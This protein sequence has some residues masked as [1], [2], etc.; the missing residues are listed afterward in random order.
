MTSIHA[1]ITT[2][3]SLM[4]GVIV[5]M[6][7]LAVADL[8]LL[9]RQVNEGAAVAG[10]KDTALE[11]RRF[12]KNLLL[13]GDRETLAEVR[14][15]RDDAAD[16]L[17][18]HRPTLAAVADA[19][20]LARLKADLDDYAT[21]LDSLEA[22][23]GAD[24]V[25]EER[26]RTVGHRITTTA[27]EMAQTERRILAQSVSR[28]RWGLVIALAL[29]V[30]AVAAIGRRFAAAVVRPLRRMEADLAPIAEG[31]LDH[32]EARTDDLE[33]VTFAAAF[34]RMLAELESRRRRLLQSEKLASLGVLVAGVAHELN[35]PL[36]NISSSAQLLIEDLDSADRKLLAQWAGQIESETERARRIV[37]ALLDFG[38]QRDFSL[39]PAAL[40]RLLEKTLILLQ[41]PLR[42]SGAR[43]DL[44]VPGDIVIL[45]DEQRLQQV[46]INLV[47]NAME[48][49]EDRV[50]IRIT[51]SPCGR[52]APTLPD[53]A[54]VIGNPNCGAGG[55]RLHTQIT[56][57]DDGPGIDPDILPR[58]FDPFFTTHEP[59][60]GYGLGLYIVQEIIQE[61]EGCIA[62]ASAPGRGTR[63]LLRLPCAEEND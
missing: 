19:P 26:I 18:L 39:T 13:Y 54:E 25:L 2:A 58:I 6:A 22:G 12:E 45:A 42:K 40:D 50:R 41:G 1:R 44:E 8:A 56:V 49:T 37:S 52:H 43:I 17:A 61:H 34:N 31:R 23:P 4:I 20:T 30:L 53:D 60:R 63:F 7:V 16:K 24:P 5:V 46:F 51:A 11:M 36:S 62:V 10:L 28:A 14:S 35:N 33:L 57:E 32:L 3:F 9:E 48:S 38:R 29:V 47:R 15:F 27:E 21:I 55:G 59:G